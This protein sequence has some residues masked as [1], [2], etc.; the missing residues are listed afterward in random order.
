M[1]DFPN[2]EDQIPKVDDS[3]RRCWPGSHVLSL[4]LRSL[5]LLRIAYGFV[6]ICDT[7]VR[8]TDL[9]AHYSDFGVLTREQLLDLCWNNNWFSLHLASGSMVWLNGLFALQVLCAGALFLGWHTRWAT[10]LSWLLLIS[11][12]GRNPLVLNGG[13][14]YL[15]V[16]LFWMLFL[17]WGHVWSLDA[18]QRQGDHRFWMPAIKGHS[19]RGVAP[20]ALAV[21]ISSVYWFA[22]IPKTHPS[23]M[24]DYSATKLALRLD[25]FLT[26]A[27]YF[28]RDNFDAHL[29]LLTCVVI[30]WEVWGPFFLFFPFDKGQVRVVAILGF[31]ALHM[32]F[33]T[34][35]YLGFFAWV[36]CLTP[37]VLL[38]SWLWDGPLKKA[39][40]WAD[41]KFGRGRAVETTKGVGVVRELFFVFILVYCFVW[42]L[43]NEDCTPK[44]FR[45][46]PSVARLGPTLRLDQRWNMFSPSPLTEDGWFVIEGRFKDG[47]VLDLFN[48]GQEVTWL[49]PDDVANT[50]KNQR[51]RKFLMNLWLAE[52]EKYRL[53]YGQYLSR[54]WNRKGRGPHELTSFELIY[55]LEKTMLN[56]RES[57]P[58]KMVIWKHWCFDPPPPEVKLPGAHRPPIRPVNPG[59]SKALKKRSE[60]LKQRSLSD[61][62]KHLKPKNDKT[63]TE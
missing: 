56:G 16:I 19:I 1:S 49:K 14:I 6:L 39:T 30:W 13:D 48:N 5:A 57:L 24:V 22:A 10:G 17:P 3:P 35:M 15:R 32:G 34:M 60:R 62:V 43:Q 52:N 21:Q 53:P 45:I 27:G 41:K 63:S 20:V 8:W 36:G 23:W 18:N 9:R 29:A 40:R 31:M 50:Y 58:Q 7:I 12:H 37:L 4:D 42:N 47:R 44:Q 26:P 33:G 25:Q 11:I 55:M 51:W 46:H 61:T 28:F 2:E 59:L 54:L 38:P